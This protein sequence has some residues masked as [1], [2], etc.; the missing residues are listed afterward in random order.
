M[1]FAVLFFARLV[2]ESFGDKT[3]EQHQQSECDEIDVDLFI[4]QIND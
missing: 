3:R 4:H 2:D 1:S